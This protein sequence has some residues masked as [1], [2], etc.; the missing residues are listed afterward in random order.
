[1][2]IILYIMVNYSKQLR[3]GRLIFSLGDNIFNQLSEHFMLKGFTVT[4]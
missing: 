3:I 2:V 4:A 1:M